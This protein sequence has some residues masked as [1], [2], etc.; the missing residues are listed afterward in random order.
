MT[1]NKIKRKNNRQFSKKVSTA[2][3]VPNFTIRW[4]LSNISEILPCS[5]EPAASLGMERKAGKVI[6]RN[7]LTLM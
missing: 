3:V 1:A 4:S 7:D 5:S 6:L 2:K